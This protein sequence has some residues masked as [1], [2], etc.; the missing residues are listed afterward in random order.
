[1]CIPTDV[2]PGGGGF[3][4]QLSRTGD[5]LWEG[6]CGYPHFFQVCVG[7]HP[8]LRLQSFLPLPCE[9]RGSNSSKHLTPGLKKR[10]GWFPGASH[11]SSSS[12]STSDWSRSSVGVRFI[13]TRGKSGG[14]GRKW[15]VGGK[16]REWIKQTRSRSSTSGSGA[17]LFPHPCAQKTQSAWPTN[18]CRPLWFFKGAQTPQTYLNS[19]SR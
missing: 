1:M 15:I 8:I 13:E 6:T 3:Y 11:A 18:P 16:L 5:S 2:I 7:R 17:P 10:C 9:M 14:K 12:D 4:L 19:N